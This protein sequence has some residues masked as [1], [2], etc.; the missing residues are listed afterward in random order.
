MKTKLFINIII[1]TVIATGCKKDEI[2]PPN[3]DGNIKYVTKDISKTTTW[4]S[5]TIY[6]ID[7]YDFYIGAGLTIE[8]GT[9]IKFQPGS[10]EYMGVGT[11]GTITA[12]GTATQPIIFT[13]YKDDAHG[14]DTNN[15][16]TATS[17]SPAD[18]DHINLNNENGSIFNYCKFLYGGNGSYSYTLTLFG[19]QNTKVSNCTF[20]YNR[21]GKFGDFYYGALDA[22]NAETGTII[23]DN[24]FYKNNIPLSISMSFNIDNSNIFHN[25]QALS[26]TNVLNGIFTYAIDEISGALYWEEDEVA[27]VINDND[28]WITEGSSLNLSNDMV[29]KFTSES[30]IVIAAGANIN[31]G[32][33]VYFTSFKDD[34]KKGDTNGDLSATMANNNDWVGI[35]DNSMI[36]PSPYYFTWS[37]IFYD[38]Y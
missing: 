18:W 22:S 31:Q 21:G 24:V 5:D 28:L 32:D 14:G 19:S 8:A 2:I 29:L 15:D 12:N 26:E 25:P 16:G 13:S 3:I 9:I 35:Y 27:F 34:S 10:G 33:N 20:A 11:G 37:N 1:L 6:V 30:E 36:I 17:A 38:S 4:Y 7:N 23:T